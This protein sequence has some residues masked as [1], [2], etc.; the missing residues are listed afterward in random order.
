MST[1]PWVEGNTIRLL[2]N[3]EE[4]FPRVFEVIAA[5]QQDVMV[6]TFILFEDEV[7]MQLKAAL[8]AAAARG[9]AV[10]L[11]VDGWGS[12]D[13]SQEY[14]AELVTAG[15]RVHRVDHQRRIFGIRPNFFRRLHR[16]LVVVDQKTG[17][18][19]GINYS[20]DHLIHHG[21]MS[22]QDFAAE[23]TGPIVDHMHAFMR[24]ALAPSR[25]EW[26][27]LWNWGRRPAP[28]KT[29]TT[30]PTGQVRATLVTRDNRRHRTDIERQY[31]AAIRTARKRLIIANAYFLPGLRLLRQIA[32][33]A[34]R[35]VQV[36]MIL[37]GN[38]DMPAAVL[39]SS[40]LYAYL[41]AAGVRI[42]EFCE[43]PLHGKVAVMD[44]AWATIGSSNLDPFSL[45]LNLEANLMI[46]D[47][48]FNQE[49]GNR[50]QGLIDHSCKRVAPSSIRHTVLHAI[51]SVML[52][53]L[54]RW[55]PRMI[56]SLPAH[57]PDI[58][59]AVPDADPGP[60]DT[61]GSQAGPGKLAAPPY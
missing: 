24:A 27:R 19:G 41:M 23:V 2:E 28:Q 43:R 38:P 20:V 52:F 16:K 22:K 49:L 56:G 21:P 55:L 45:S 4:F 44:D 29:S 58:K 37:Q 17:F 42:H 33:A 30:E 50:L 34:R 35:G 10:D 36:D 47:H 54:L 3:G 11:T 1:G 51:G 13:L 31:M 57:A 40:S 46:Q 9:A 15:V 61:P 59:P 48:A 26:R 25:R 53:H 5:A 8:L 12:V 39:G 18:I 7:G 60:D 6:E 32:S 14:I